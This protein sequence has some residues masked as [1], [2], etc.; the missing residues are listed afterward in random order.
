MDMVYFVKD[1]KFDEKKMILN[2]SVS[3]FHTKKSDY[4]PIKSLEKVKGKLVNLPEKDNIAVLQDELCLV[5]PQNFRFSSVT[6]KG[7]SNLNTAIQQELISFFKPTLVQG[8]PSLCVY[9]SIGLQDFESLLLIDESAISISSFICEDTFY[10][11]NIY[12]LTRA[13]PCPKCHAYHFLTSKTEPVK[14]HLTDW[15]KFFHYLMQNDLLNLSSHNLQDSTI[16]VASK[17][18]IESI[19]SKIVK[20]YTSSPVLLGSFYQSINLKTFFSHVDLAK[21][22]Y[23]CECQYHD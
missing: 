20:G 15:R 22:H 21:A 8:Y 23:S 4:Y 3:T 17:I 13:A 5:E 1:F 2:N 18:L 7:N 9:F 16:R 14:K 10:L 6:V 12:G 19:K 11:S